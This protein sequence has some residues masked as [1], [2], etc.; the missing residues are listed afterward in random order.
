V[1]I[2]ED[3]KLILDNIISILQCVISNLQSV[4]D[5]FDQLEQR[6]RNH[7]LLGDILI[8]LESSVNILEQLMNKI[9]RQQKE[10]FA[11]IQS[12]EREFSNSIKSLKEKFSEINN[13]YADLAQ[14]FMLLKKDVSENYQTLQSKFSRLYNRVENLENIINNLLSNTAT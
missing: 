12:M 2:N 13:E 1:A 7:K 11:L 14:K 9:D 8:L 6:T 4:S 5:L 10:V 3:E